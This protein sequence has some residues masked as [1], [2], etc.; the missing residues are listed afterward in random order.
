MGQTSQVGGWWFYF[1]VAFA[2]KAP[3]ALLAA[4]LS[5]LFVARRPSPWRRL[6]FVYYTLAV[7]LVLYAG[8]AI[9]SRLTIGI[10][11]L[12]PVWPLLVPLVAA[13]LVR[14]RTLAVLVAA[15]SIGEAVWIYPHHLAHFNLAAGG[16]SHGERWLLDS[17]LDWAQDAKRLRKWLDAHGSPPVCFAYF[18]TADTAYYGVPANGLTP[19]SRGCVG[20]ISA[21]LLHDLYLEPGTYAWLRAK[22]PIGRAGYSIFL[23]DLRR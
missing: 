21:N 22:K 13:P 11:H 16:P 15:L 19:Q 4:I 17:N 12:L 2:V 1:P 7:P 9:N 14:R 10:R 5:V 3:L 23:Y 18:G 6:P 20:A 8:L